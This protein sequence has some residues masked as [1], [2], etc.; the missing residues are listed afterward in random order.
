[1]LFQPRQAPAVKHRQVAVA[2]N[3]CLLRCAWKPPFLAHQLSV[4]VENT[5]IDPWFHDKCFRV[6][7]VQPCGCLRT[8][9]DHM[10]NDLIISRIQLVT[11]AVPLHGMPVHFYR[12]GPPQRANPQSR[13]QKIRS[14][15]LVVLSG[16]I[17]PYSLTRLGVPLAGPQQAVSPDKM[18]DGFVHAAK[19]AHTVA[20]QKFNFDFDLNTIKNIQ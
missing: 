1:M 8:F 15:I 3:Q 9:P 20:L 19:L 17:Q 7:A 6:A 16:R 4:V 12:P 11:V 2:V 5:P 13:P 10:Q 18:H 14:R